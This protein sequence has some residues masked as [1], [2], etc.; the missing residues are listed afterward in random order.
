MSRVKIYVTFD[1][2]PDNSSTSAER[3]DITWHGIQ[4]IPSIDEYLSSCSIPYTFFLRCDNQIRDIYGAYL[5]IYYEHQEL[6]N[7]L[8]ESG[9]E[10]GWHPHLYKMHEGSY[11]PL[12][13]KDK[14]CD[15]L[16]QA[17]EEIAVI[18]YKI[19]SVRLGEAWHSTETMCALDSIG[20]QVDSTAV[21]GRS[22]QDEL[23]S[24]DWKP[25]PNR[26]YHPSIYDYRVPGETDS[27]EILEVPMTT[28]IIKTDYDRVPLRRYLNPTY[29]SELFNDG[30]V[31]CLTEVKKEGIGDIVLIFHPD[32][33]LGHEPNG[34]YSYDWNTF[35][36][37]ID[38]FQN[39]L[40]E[41]DVDWKFCCLRDV[42]I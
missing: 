32:E 31:N 25:T 10:L 42:L 34:L 12:R 37:N 40:C 14:C 6:W 16:E 26:P 22:R 1:I 24:F 33:L 9:N 13:N 15:I 17:W 38:S 29:H 30:M 23:R 39:M 35:T 27:L 11:I 21:P 19:K 18:D 7:S 8:I 3:T 4:K 20:L 5:G 2:D 36:S 28:T 41:Y